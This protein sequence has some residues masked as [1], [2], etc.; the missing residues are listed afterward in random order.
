MGT[1]VETTVLRHLFA[2]YYRDTPEIVYWRDAATNREVD[3]IVRSPAY[4][5]PFEVKYR[6]HP[7]LD[8]KSG[9]GAYCMSERPKQAYLVTKRDVDFAVT[10]LKGIET[11][12]LKIPAFILCYLLGQSER[13]LWE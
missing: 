1:I 10:G 11:S 6:E 7:S 5:L 9:L 8:K 13:L 3:I 4:V 12:F 2:Y